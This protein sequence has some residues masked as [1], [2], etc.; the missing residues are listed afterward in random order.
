VLRKRV[1]AEIEAAGGMLEVGI[2]DTDVAVNDM[3]GRNRRLLRTAR[4]VPWF[5]EIFPFH[6]DVWAWAEQRRAEL[7]ARG[8][9][10]RT[11]V[12][13]LE[14]RKPKLHFKSQFFGSPESIETLIPRPEWLPALRNFSDGMLEQAASGDQYVDVKTARAAMENDLQVLGERW[15]SDLSP[16]QRERVIQYLLTG[17]QNQDYRGKIMDGEVTFV[18]SHM[19]AILGYLDFVGLMAHT[20]WVETAEEMEPLLPIQSDRWRRIGRFIRN[21][22]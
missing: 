14:E 9:E 3:I 10:P 4:E 12:Q 20:T 22:L 15:W 21:A 18:V 19:G 11:L 7:Q 1:R 5:R 2:Y 17:S 13:D 8:F 6:P 16:D